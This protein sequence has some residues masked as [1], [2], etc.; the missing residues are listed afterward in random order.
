MSGISRGVIFSEKNAPAGTLHNIA[1][2]LRWGGGVTV[3]GYP[4]N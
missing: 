4:R 1:Q 3:T 2:G